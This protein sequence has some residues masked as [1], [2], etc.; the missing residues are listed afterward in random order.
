VLIFPSPRWTHVNVKIGELAFFMDVQTKFLYGLRQYEHFTAHPARVEPCRGV[1][2]VLAQ[3]LVNALCCKVRIEIEKMPS[4]A[5]HCSGCLCF[6][7]SWWTGLDMR[8]A[9]LE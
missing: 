8:A 6:L 3:G 1:V 5:K 9:S 4:N 7:K 2:G